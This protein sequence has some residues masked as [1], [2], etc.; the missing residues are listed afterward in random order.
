[1]IRHDGEG[2]RVVSLLQDAL[3]CCCCTTE[4]LL[5]RASSADPNLPTSFKETNIFM[6]SVTPAHH[7]SHLG[8]EKWIPAHPHEPPTHSAFPAAGR[9]GK[10]RWDFYTA[11]TEHAR[12]QQ[13]ESIMLHHNSS[14]GNQAPLGSFSPTG[15]Q[16]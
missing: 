1:M 6:L 2:K 4:F 9:L 15:V 7:P 10:A 16:H 14:R 3:A 12:C 8:C 11:S 13:Q 5:P